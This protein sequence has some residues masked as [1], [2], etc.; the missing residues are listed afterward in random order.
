MLHAHGISNHLQ[1]QEV[2][3]LALAT[4]EDSLHYTPTAAAEAVQHCV[5]ATTPSKHPAM[6]AIL[7]RGIDGHAQYVQGDLVGLAKNV[8]A[9]LQ[10]YRP[11]GG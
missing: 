2:H 11:T 6:N 4:Y 3:A 10:H 1:P 8:N 9:V 7:H 5:G